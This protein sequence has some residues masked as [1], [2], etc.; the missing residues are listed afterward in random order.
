[1]IIYFKK[2]RTNILLLPNLLFQGTRELKERCGAAG[3]DPSPPPAFVFGDSFFAQTPFGGGNQNGGG[4]K[5]VCLCR[6]LIVLP[7]Y[8]IAPVSPTE[9]K[10]QFYQQ[11]E[12]LASGGAGRRDDSTQ[13]AVLGGEVKGQEVWG[14]SDVYFYFL[15]FILANWSHHQ[16]PPTS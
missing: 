2:N 3:D 5:G 6:L 4:T 8:Y 13:E 10:C 9:K 14:Y 1:M 16:G 15:C 12:P 7:P 11:V